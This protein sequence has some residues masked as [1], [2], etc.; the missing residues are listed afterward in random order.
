ARPLTVSHLPSKNP[1]KR[2]S[3]LRTSTEILCPSPVTCLQRAATATLLAARPIAAIVPNR[4]ELGR[5]GSLPQKLSSPPQSS[6]VMP[7]SARTSF[8]PFFR[9]KSG[10]VAGS[11]NF[12]SSSSLNRLLSAFVSTDRSV[13]VAVPIG[14][15]PS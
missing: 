3:A 2:R 6:L 8:T 15:S 7:T 9:S 13:M 14:G 12:F 10:D 1:Q 5:I 4:S 11:L